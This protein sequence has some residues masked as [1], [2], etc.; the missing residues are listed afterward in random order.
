M[1]F[2]E[3]YTSASYRNIVT[4][5][6]K[7]VGPCVKMQHSQK[8]EFPPWQVNSGNG[9]KQKSS[10]V[11]VSLFDLSDIFIIPNRSKEYNFKTPKGGI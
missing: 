1:Y 11:L 7:K 6:P 10:Q 3:I 5:L 8:I 9:E 4:N 2:K